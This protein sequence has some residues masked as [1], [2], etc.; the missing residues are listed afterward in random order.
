MNIEGLEVDKK[1]HVVFMRILGPQEDPHRVVH[2]AGAVSELLGKLRFDEDIRVVIL[3]AKRERA[4]CVSEKT[5]ARISQTMGSGVGIFPSIADA[6]SKTEV[7]VIA[8]IERDAVG[9]GLEWILACDIRIA[10]EKSRF[11]LPHVKVGL[12]PSEGGTQRL[13]EKFAF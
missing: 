3:E 10:S 6:L 1:N 5:L 4:L 7:P 11:G 9:L 13:E 8:G 12:L 2:L